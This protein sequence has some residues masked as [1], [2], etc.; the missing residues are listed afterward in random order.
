MA[1][2][3]KTFECLMCKAPIKL[4]RKDN[5]WVR[6]NLDG[7]ADVDQKKQQQQKRPQQQ[8]STT[9]TDV[10]ISNDG[11]ASTEALLRLILLEQQTHF[12][13]IDYT[14]AKLTSTLDALSIVISSIYEELQQQQQ[15]EE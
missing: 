15:Q 13:K 7:T 14:L 6:W 4:E 11:G 3:E 2:M 12:E 1:A 5:R 9:T 10:V 8:Q